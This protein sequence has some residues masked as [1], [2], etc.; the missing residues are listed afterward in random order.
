MFK[1][2]SAINTPDVA[3]DGVARYHSDRDDLA[4]LDPRSVQHMGDQV[5][6]LVESLPTLGWPGGDPSESALAYLDVVGIWLLRWPESWSLWIC[7]IVT[8]LSWW[9]LVRSAFVTT[10]SFGATVRR[11]SWALGCVILAPAIAFAMASAVHAFAAAYHGTSNRH[12]YGS[13]ISP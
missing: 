1:S 2:T 4:H 8:L 7:A 3:M 12:P 11:S 5:L 6:A 9:T 10:R 13:S